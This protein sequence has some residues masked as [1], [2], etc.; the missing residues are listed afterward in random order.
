MTA[1]TDCTGGKDPSGCARR[2]V[3]FFLLSLDCTLV[4]RGR[5]RGTMTLRRHGAPAESLLRLVVRGSPCWMSSRTHRPLVRLDC[6]VKIVRGKHERGSENYSRHKCTV[7][8]GCGKKGQHVQ[9]KKHVRGSGT[10][11]DANKGTP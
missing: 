8:A 11:G 5:L 10:K 6:G 4:C 7:V 3:R 9:Q 2:K 1:Q